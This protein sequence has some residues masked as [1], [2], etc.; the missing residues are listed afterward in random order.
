MILE[1]TQEMCYPSVCY[2]LEKNIVL[3]KQSHWRKASQHILSVKLWQ[4]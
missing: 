3:P 2:N 4:M 1:L